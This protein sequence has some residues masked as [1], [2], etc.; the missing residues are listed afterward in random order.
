LAPVKGTGREAARGDRKRVWWT[1]LNVGLCH[2][3]GEARR[4]VFEGVQS[5]FQIKG[6]ALARRRGCVR[7]GERERSFVKGGELAIVASSGDGADDRQKN[8]IG[9]L[10]RF[11][12]I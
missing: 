9:G 12:K 1:P 11:K 7:R 8:R 3:R 4:T 6:E 2:K 5:P 10:M